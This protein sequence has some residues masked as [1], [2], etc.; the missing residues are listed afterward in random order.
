MVDADAHPQSG[1]GDIIMSCWISE[2]SK[3]SETELIHAVHGKN[4]RQILKMFQQAITFDKTNA[5]NVAEAYQTDLEIGDSFPR[6]ETRRKVLGITAPIK[7][8]TPY[9]GSKSQR[10]ADAV[11][12][13][14]TILLYPQ[15]HWKCREWPT[16]YWIDLA[17]ALKARGFQPIT[18][19]AYR[20]ERYKK[21]PQ[22]FV[23]K[24]WQHNAALMNR[25]QLV[26]GNDSAG[27]HLAGTLDVPCLALVGPT[28]EF[29][30]SHCPS[31]RL[32]KGGMDC[33]GCNFKMRPACKWGCSSLFTI[34]VERVLKEI[35]GLQD[36]HIDVR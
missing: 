29:A 34:T 9:I 36:C 3:G 21:T 33:Q 17:W 19:L 4:N 2:G 28:T 26:V 35:D 30:F 27:A 10:W 18:M 8:P 32:V 24:S 25:S 31:V 5:I 14:R 22:S 15:T 13:G 11:S 6:I 1:I 20:D 12:N 23:G 16:A 7:R